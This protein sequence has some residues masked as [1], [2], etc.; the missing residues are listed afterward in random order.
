MVTGSKGRLIGSKLVPMQPPSRICFWMNI[1]S[2]H[3]S[4]FFA[5]I[6]RSGL[7]DLQVRY[8][9]PPDQSRRE[10]GWPQDGRHEPY[11]RQLTAEQ[12]QSGA[13]ATVPDWRSRVHI[14]SPFNTPGVA[15]QLHK[16]GAT[17]CY[18]A[19]RPGIRIAELV[20]FHMALFT[21]ADRISAV[22]NRRRYRLWRTYAQRVLVQGD[23]A[24]EG[25]ARRGVSHAAMRD[26]FYSPAGVRVQSIDQEGQAGRPCTF[27]YVGRLEPCKGTDV[28][29]KA[30]ARMNDR[31]C[32]LVLIGLDMSSGRYRELAV[33]LGVA[34]R[35]RFAGAIPWDRVGEEI[36]QSDVL[37]LPSRWDGWGA[38]LNEGASAGLPLI[39]TDMCG[40][41]FHAIVEG[42]NGVV[43]RRSRIRPLQLAMETYAAS[44]ELR[45]QHGLE[46]ARLFEEVLSAEANVRRLVAA[47]DGVKPHLAG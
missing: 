22:V 41:S 45:R 8:V 28:L 42:V 16:A 43:V 6:A 12:R 33:R 40:A 25:F 30:F 19:E 46:S 18:W 26:L 47:L 10:Q 1:E 44:P 21:L 20:R 11:E 5:A 27:V 32:R 4:P 36:G 3:Q 23:L 7:F 34:E 37:V 14:V 17:V 24:R 39:G 2:P 9:N 29:I 31:D 38:V 13:L 15:D 35:V